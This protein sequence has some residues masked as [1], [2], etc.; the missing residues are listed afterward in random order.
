MVI[1]YLGTIPICHTFTAIVSSIGR[2]LVFIWSMYSMFNVMFY[3][4]MLRSTL[5]S[6][7]LEKPIDTHEDVLERGSTVYIPFQNHRLQ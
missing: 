6:E 2:F 5:V 4:S 7:D 1:R 3:Q